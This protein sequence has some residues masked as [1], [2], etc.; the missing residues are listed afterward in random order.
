M[1]AGMARR[2]VNDWREKSEKAWAVALVIAWAALI[3]AGALLF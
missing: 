3:I 2:H 1:G